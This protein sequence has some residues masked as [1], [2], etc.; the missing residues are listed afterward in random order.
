[1]RKRVKLIIAIATP[2]MILAGPASDAA[3]RERAVAETVL[4]NSTERLSVGASHACE[5]QGDGT[6]RCWG[7]NS[8]GQ[9]GD[10]T[11][12]NTDRP[13][14]T[15]VPS[16]TL[17]IDPSVGLVEGRERMATVHVLASCEVG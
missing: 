14:P 17:D 7:N 8:S 3:M 4:H 12:T 1:M 6:V 9:L 2:I 10:G 5:V 15:T 16:F 11:T 13:R